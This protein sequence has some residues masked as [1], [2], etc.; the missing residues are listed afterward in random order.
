MSLDIVS[1]T[2]GLLTT[3]CFF[4]LSLFL[5]VGI[6]AIALFVKG[7][8]NSLFSPP[9][10]KPVQQKKR[11]PRAKIRTISINPDEVDRVQFKKPC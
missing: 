2:L 7:K 4:V 5:V 6:K 10:Q 3:A 8:F 11:K 9:E 1:F